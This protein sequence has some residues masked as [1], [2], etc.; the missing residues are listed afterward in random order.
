MGLHLISETVSK[1]HLK[2]RFGLSVERRADFLGY[3]KD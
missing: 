2:H 1:T 3:W